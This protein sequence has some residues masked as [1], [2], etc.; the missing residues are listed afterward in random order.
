MKTNYFNID[1]RLSE[2]AEQTE[3]DIKPAFERIEKTAFINQQKVLAAFIGN[4]VGESSFTSS[5]GYGYGDIGRDKLE[6]VFADAMECEDALV[7]HNFMCGTHALTVAL[8][9]VL[10]PGD[11]MLCV[12]GMPYDTIQSVIGIS[13]QPASG[14]LRD[15]GISFKKVDLLPDGKVDI[16]GVIRALRSDRSVKMVYIQRS[17]GYSLR[18]SLTVENIEEICVQVRQAKPEVIIMVV[19]STGGY[20]AGRSDLVEMCSYRLS[21][22]GTGREVGC[23]LG[24]SREMYMGLFSAPHVVGEALKTASFCAGLFSG[25]GYEVTPQPDEFRADII[26]SVMLR[27]PKALIAFCQGIQSGS[28]VD[29]MALPEPWDMPG[30]DNKIIMASGSFTL[31][32]SIELSA[33]APLREPFAVWMQGGLNYAAGKTGVLIAAQRMLDKGLIRL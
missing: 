23:T 32:S 5:T 6:R 10:R 17:R 11:S 1:D 18:P 27:E 15:F 29:S 28:P 8:F 9:G 13:K 26:Q 22:P 33:D 19:S 20:I 30:Y 4:G 2:L 31:G 7:R 3:K 16:E 14:S 12:T 24:H 25:L 21:T